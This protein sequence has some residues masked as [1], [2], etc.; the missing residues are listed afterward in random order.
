MLFFDT[1]PVGRI[2]SRFSKDLSVGDFIVPMIVNWF[3]QCSFK[4]VGVII[5][6][7]IAIPWMLIPSVI[8]FALLL[9]AR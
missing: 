3:F 6:V 7:C 2:A 4:I 8:I 9:L 5:V 1:N